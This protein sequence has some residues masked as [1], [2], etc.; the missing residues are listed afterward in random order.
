MRRSIL[1]VIFWLMSCMYPQRVSGDI[2]V[3]G[4]RAEHHEEHKHHSHAN[5]LGASLGYVYMD[6]EGE[7]AAGLHLHYMRRLRGDGIQRHFGLGAGFEAILADHMH[8][9]VMGSLGIY[10]YRALV[11]IISPGV[12][13]VEHH[14]EFETRYSTHVEA[15]YGFTLG[16]FHVGPVIGFA[17]SG[18][19]TH[20]MAG[21][22]FGKGF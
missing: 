10:P 13:I 14:D 20:Y 5:E 15:A 8:Y 3:T 16:N 7:S 12:L 6:T 17:R 1:I 18:D 9:N 22:H 4:S 19:D 11:L 2:V 21:V